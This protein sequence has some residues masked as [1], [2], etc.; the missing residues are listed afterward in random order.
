M[1]R[2]RFT[3]KSMSQT[4]L[5]PISIDLSP[6]ESDI[7]EKNVHLLRE[8]GVEVNHFGDG[9][10]RIE[11]LPYWH[12]KGDGERVIYDLIAG[13][14]EM[15]RSVSPEEALEKVFIVLA[16]HGAIRGHRNLQVEEVGELLREMDDTPSVSRCPHGR[17]TYIEIDRQELDRRFGRQK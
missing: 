15:G 7:L 3:E 4:L 6:R 14:M 16:C 9:T 11:A 12:E 13:F 17:P 5:I 8:V 10:W 1:K 2:R